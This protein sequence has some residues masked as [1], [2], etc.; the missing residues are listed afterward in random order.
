MS[1]SRISRATRNYRRSFL[2]AGRVITNNMI[3]D[4]RSYQ[5]PPLVLTLVCVDQSPG[6]SPSHRFREMIKACIDASPAGFQRRPYGEVLTNIKRAAE[7]IHQAT[8]GKATRFPYI[9]Q[10]F[11]EREVVKEGVSKSLEVHQQRQE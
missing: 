9:G 2:H 11:V 3:H 8:V 7:I 10:Y 6:G 4:W 5:A 1:S